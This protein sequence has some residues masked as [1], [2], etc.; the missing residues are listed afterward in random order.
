MKKKT[1]LGRLITMIILPVAVLFTVSAAIGLSTV[2]NALKS[3]SQDNVNNI[4]TLICSEI[5]SRISSYAITAKNKSN[6]EEIRLFLL[7]NPD[8]DDFMFSN[9]YPDA[10]EV[11]DTVISENSDIFSVGFI[12][13]FT[14]TSLIFEN[15]ASGWS[16]RYD[17]DVTA[18][19]YYKPLISGSNDCFITDPYISPSD[20]RL[21]VTIAC[22]VKGGRGN[23]VLGALGLNIP[24][25]RL[26]SMISDLHFSGD[27]T[28]IILDSTEH[29]L[30]APK[31]IPAD[32]TITP[33]GTSGGLYDFI[34]GDTEMLG[35][36]LQ[37]SSSGWTVYSMS[38]M[39]EVRRTVE[40]EAGRYLLIYVLTII[41]IVIILFFVSHSVSKPISDYTAEIKKHLADG[42]NGADVTSDPE[43]MSPKGIYEIEQLAESFNALL[44]KNAA[45]LEELRKMNIS[46]ERERQLYRTAVESSADVVFEYDIE[47]DILTSYGS[48]IDRDAPKTSQELHTSFLDKIRFSPDN[49]A[50]EKED[51]ERFFGG[52]CTVPVR[53]PLKYIRDNEQLTIW[54]VFEGK[55]IYDGETPVRIVGKIRN[56]N[57]V[58]KLKDK[59]E[60]DAL[61]G[62]FNKEY[63]ENTISRVVDA[64]AAGDRFAMILIDIDNFKK[65]ND[66]LGHNM[67]DNVLKDISE[68]LCRILPDNGIIGRIG[69]D[70]F[71]AFIKAED[72]SADIS[73]LCEQICGEIVTDYGSGNDIIRISSSIGISM[74]PEHGKTFSEL[75]TTADIAMYVTKT[76][77]KNGFTLYDGQN[78]P[79][80]RSDRWDD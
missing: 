36:K 73:A 38:P 69:G 19:P 28:T 16:G 1:L 7:D 25:E 41:I 46:S 4:T 42:K 58:I 17:F 78:R 20:G 80:Y 8:R 14:D 55:T 12:A 56:I 59:A 62:V 60:K 70:E 51:A 66:S 37:V 79:N 67:G 63:T 52:D 21:I 31:N 61:T 34:C 23:P 48:V 45:M 9:Y 24:V 43:K 64:A 10:I 2:S 22:A 47:T 53:L 26:G 15:S 5:N 40:N 71:L 35:N 32:A 54:V 57:D 49:S 3:I 65:I 13:S 74:Y 75:Y 33:N 30:A 77:G 72:E 39:S 44:E 18:M 76:N 11:L 6:S 29:I 27:Y 50:A 68:K